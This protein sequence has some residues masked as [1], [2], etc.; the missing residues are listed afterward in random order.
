MKVYALSDLHVD[1]PQN[2]QWLAQLVREDFGQDVLI[3][4][5][6]ICDDMGLLEDS[7]ASL[8][9]C[10]AEVLFVPG[11]HDLWV[12]DEHFDCSLEKFSAIRALCD[13][14]GVHTRP[15]HGDDL[16]IVPLFSWYD[17]SFGAPDT[18][19]RRAWRDFRACRWPSHL[20]D[21][22]AVTAHFL[23]LNESH[24]DT[25]NDTVISFSHFLPSLAV[26]PE[27]IPSHR[28]KVYPVLGSD[29]LGEQ[30]QRLR[31]DIHVYGHSHVN[32]AIELD[33]TL[34]INNA[35]A[36]PAEQR[37]ARKALY[38]VWQGEH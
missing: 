34:F 22:E 7:L 12:R 35:F 1:Y 32:Q 5:G 36:Y 4:A 17:F 37:I 25:R 16:S 19:L 8:Q 3:L 31:P 14:L 26:M 11:N 24:L 20:G 38:C 30:L 23:G 10:F 33:A 21:A 29:R 27:R 18:W 13:R 15:W 2:R 28:R 6:D 9:N